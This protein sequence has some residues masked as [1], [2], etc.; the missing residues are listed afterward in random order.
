MVHEGQ[1]QPQTLKAMSPEPTGSRKPALRRQK[2]RQGTSP[3]EGLRW[4]VGFGRAELARRVG[5]SE[6]RFRSRFPMVHNI[7]TQIRSVVKEEWAISLI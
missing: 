5:E 6:V 2:L 3:V 7:E 4:F 1:H